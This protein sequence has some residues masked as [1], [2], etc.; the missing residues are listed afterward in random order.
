MFQCL[1]LLTLLGCEK[2]SISDC[3]P[4]WLLEVH[5]YAMQ[6]LYIIVRRASRRYRLKYVYSALG[7]LAVRSIYISTLSFLL[8][9]PVPYHALCR[10]ETFIKPSIFQ[11]KE[12]SFT[13]IAHGRQHYVNSILLSSQWFLCLFEVFTNSLQYKNA[14]IAICVLAVPFEIYSITKACNLYM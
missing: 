2:I 11:K 1:T 10:K 13:E 7:L 6:F 8:A 9:M 12:N 14:N 4:M 5:M 3:V